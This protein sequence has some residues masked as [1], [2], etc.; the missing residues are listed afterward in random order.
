MGN[1]AKTENLVRDILRKKGYY[2]NPDIIVEEKKSD[3]PSIDKLLKNASKKGNKRGYPEFIISS[4]INPEFTIV[5]ECKADNSKHI[6][7]DMDCYS[8]FAVDGA[9][10]Y[11]SFLSREFDVLAIGVSGQD[12]NELR[13]THYMH[14]KGSSKATP[15][16]GDELLSFEAYLTGYLKSPEKFRQDYDSLLAFSRQLNQELHSYKIL[17]SQRG[18]LISCIL[19]ALENKAFRAAYKEYDK[20]EDLANALV[21][22]VTNELKRANIQPK[23]LANLDVQF[24]FIRTDTTLAGQEGVLLNLIDEIDTNI[25]HFIKTHEYFDVLGQ[26][27]IEFLRYANSDK[28]LGIVLTPPHIT[29]LFCDLANV[30]VNSVVYDNCTG[31]AGFLISAMRKMI[32]AAK[33]DIDKERRVKEKQVIGVEYQAHIFALACSNMFIHQDGKTNIIPGSC[34]DKTIM[35]Y[36]KQFKPNI[37]LLNP[38]YQTDKKD[39]PELE[40][41]LNNLE[42]LQVGGTCVA[43][44]PIERVLATSGVKLEL[45]QRLLSKHTLEAVMSMPD[46]LFTN[47]GTGSVTVAIVVTAHKPHPLNKE[48]YFGYWKDDGFV[49]RRNRGRID[50]YNRWEAIRTKWLESYMNRKNQPGLSINKSV[51]AKDEWCAEAYMETDYSQLSAKDFTE[52]IKKFVMFKKMSLEE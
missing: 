1:E 34:F 7:K 27:Y 52:D 2:S 36:V 13:V 32:K 35:E 29:E 43:I 51:T 18:L 30:N 15:I 45:K 46:Q 40:F 48:T 50:A 11:A 6:S 8:E 31:T 22:T 49:L 47:S 21:D 16:F 23:K 28:S 9:L 12:M 19:I 37:G 33:G 38:P 41:I 17:E 44:V 4:K 24:S 42:V 26:L 39:I 3:Y 14:L 5:I 25:N 10:L 20:P